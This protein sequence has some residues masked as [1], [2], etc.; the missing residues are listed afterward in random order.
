[1]MAGIRF[2]WRLNARWRLGSVATFERYRSAWFDCLFV[3][4]DEIEMILGGTGWRV[5]RFIDSDRASYVAI[6]D[7]EP[8]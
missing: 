1:M 3:S 6:I 4:R 7:K 8:S 5:R 2:S